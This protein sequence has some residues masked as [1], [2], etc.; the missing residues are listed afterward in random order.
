M[1]KKDIINSILSR[2]KI[3][4]TEAREA[5]KSLL[6]NTAN[7]FKADAMRFAGKSIFESASDSGGTKEP[8]KVPDIKGHKGF[9]PTLEKPEGEDKTGH[10]FPV[11]TKATDAN[12]GKVGNVV[13]DP[14]SSTP[15]VPPASF[16]ASLGKIDTSTMFADQLPAS[17]GFKTTVAMLTGLEKGA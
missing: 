14:Y 11:G 6:S 7:Q 1:E 5:I 12:I 16:T 8:H 10:V 9:D 3:K 4:M 2:E 13:N 15:T 17:D